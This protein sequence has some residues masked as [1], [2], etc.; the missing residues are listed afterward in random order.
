[1]KVPTDIA[2]AY[3]DWGANCGPFALAAILE[4]NLTDIRASLGLFEQQRFM[5]PT[6]MQACLERLAITKEYGLDGWPGAGEL[7][8]PKV[9]TATKPEGS[10]RTGA[11]SPARGGACAPRELREQPTAKE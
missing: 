1:M 10:A 2:K 6:D 4:K 8:T 11:S 3:C 5:P 9:F 7:T